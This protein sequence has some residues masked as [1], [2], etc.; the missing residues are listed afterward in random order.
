M[1][2]LVVFAE[3]HMAK[4]TLKEAPAFEELAV[5]VGKALAARWI[6]HQLRE[7]KASGCP[8][9][10]GSAQDESHTVSDAAKVQAGQ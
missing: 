3:V 4:H 6:E 8:Q 5:V 2:G 10:G 9:Q 7:R 1:L